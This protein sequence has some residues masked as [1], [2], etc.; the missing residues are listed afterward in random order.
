MN[1]LRTTILGRAVRVSREFPV[2][3]SYLAQPILAFRI[4]EVSERKL[5]NIHAIV[6]VLP[7]WN[8]LSQAIW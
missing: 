8:V 4:V 5:A 7:L 1:R 2:G 6:A 3:C